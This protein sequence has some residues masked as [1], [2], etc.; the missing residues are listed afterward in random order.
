MIELDGAAGFW[1]GILGSGKVDRL[2]VDLG[3]VV[4]A[5]LVCGW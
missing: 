4:V 2:A 5:R 3:L 1:I